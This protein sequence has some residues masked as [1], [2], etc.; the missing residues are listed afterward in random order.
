MQDTNTDLLSPLFR[1]EL[2]QHKAE[3]KAQLVAIQVAEALHLALQRAAS[4]DIQVAVDHDK[5]YLLIR[6]PGQTEFV[7]AIENGELFSQEIG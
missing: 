2:Q 1:V 4:S 5:K 7:I 6:P 3:L